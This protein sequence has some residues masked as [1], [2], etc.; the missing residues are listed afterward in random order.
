MVK[1]VSVPNSS[2]PAS[3]ICWS[4]MITSNFFSLQIIKASSPVAA[5][6]IVALGAMPL[7]TRR[8]SIV[9]FIVI[10]SI[11][12]NDIGSS[13]MVYSSCTSS[14]LSGSS[15][16]SR[17]NSKK[18]VV[19]GLSVGSLSKP[20]FPPTRSTRCFAIA[21]PKPVPGA[22]PRCTKRWNNFDWCFLGIP[23]PVSIHS[24]RNIFPF[25]FMESKIEPTVVYFIAFVITL[26]KTCCIR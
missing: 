26:V 12:K 3:S 24:N 21:K 11:I 19:P 17:G 22:P 9:R 5:S 1:T 6:V 18:H 4:T 16:R 7:F 8:L 23:G 15:Q 13:I 25:H 20:I 14:I 10:S 2:P